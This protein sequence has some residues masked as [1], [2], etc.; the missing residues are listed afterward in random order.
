LWKCGAYRTAGRAAAHALWRD[1]SQ[2]LQLF[3]NL[4]R[5]ARTVFAGLRP[6]G[7]ST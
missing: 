3:L 4:K 1:P 2:I 7:N 6:A 5:V